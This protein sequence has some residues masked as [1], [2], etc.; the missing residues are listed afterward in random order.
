MEKIIPYIDIKKVIATWTI[1]IKI[2]PIIEESKDIKKNI[3]IINGL[4][5]LADNIERLI[6]EQL[7]FNASHS[8]Y[9]K[10]NN[11]VRYAIINFLYSFW[12]PCFWIIF[13]D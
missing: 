2:N 11:T 1:K 10:R 7:L 8:L 5:S 6:W 13:T 4:K 3:E 9:L 12:F